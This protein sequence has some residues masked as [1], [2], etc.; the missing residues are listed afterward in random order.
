[1]PS[2]PDPT[3]EQPPSPY[4]GLSY[5]EGQRPS[6]GDLGPLAESLGKMFAV[7]PFTALSAAILIDQ[8]VAADALD[9]LHLETE[10]LAVE[11]E[12]AKSAAKLKAGRSS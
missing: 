7:G 3:Q 9:L 12:E 8:G 1:M 6:T 5:Y 10:R 2:A 11:R 4:A